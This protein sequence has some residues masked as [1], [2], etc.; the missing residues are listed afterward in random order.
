[1]HPIVGPASAPDSVWLQNAVWNMLCQP[2][3]CRPLGGRGHSLL[4][5][6]GTHTADDTPKT[7]ANGRKCLAPDVHGFMTYI[8][9]P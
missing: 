7:E 2:S 5:A 6:K 4:W 1:M 9:N 8:M 3:I